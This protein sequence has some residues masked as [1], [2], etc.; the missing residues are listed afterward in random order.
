MVVNFN[1]IKKHAHNTFFLLFNT[2]KLYNIINNDF[3]II[4]N[5]RIKIKY[6][7]YLNKTKVK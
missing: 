4:I 5:L 2:F 3:G 6:L 7:I 1:Y